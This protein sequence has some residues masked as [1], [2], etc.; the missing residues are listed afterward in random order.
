M[1]LIRELNMMNEMAIKMGAWQQVIDMAV[2]LAKFQKGEEIT[3]LETGEYSIRKV[4]NDYALFKDGEILSISK[5]KDR[6]IDSK[7]YSEV[8]VIYTPQEKRRMGYSITLLYALKE[9]S[10]SPLLFYDIIFEDG[11]SLLSSIA[12]NHSHHFQGV[13]VLNKNTGEI[14]DFTGEDPKRHYAFIIEN[15]DMGFYRDY[16]SLDAR[17]YYNIFAKILED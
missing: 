7:R 17:V 2:Q 16:E 10:K 8:L 4:D 12:N 11:W 9:I 15:D 3:K 5:I 1:K 13:H 6:L 14:T